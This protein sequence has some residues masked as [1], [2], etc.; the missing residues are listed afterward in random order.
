[1]AAQGHLGHTCPAK[2][3]FTWHLDFLAPDPNP[4]STERP[5][6]PLTAPQ[7]EPEL[8]AWLGFLQG[9]SVFLCSPLFTLLLVLHT[10][11][12][13]LESPLG[14]PSGLGLKCP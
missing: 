8:Q 14:C 13:L 12:P 5:C 1:M 6:S 3:L 10:R 7:Q 4:P 9:P 2:F 11:A